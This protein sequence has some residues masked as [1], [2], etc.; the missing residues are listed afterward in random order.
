MSKRRSNCVLNSCELDSV[1]LSFETPLC[2]VLNSCKMSRSGGTFTD[3]KNAQTD[4]NGTPLYGIDK[5]LAEK[6]SRALLR[7]T[8]PA[9]LDPRAR[10]PE[11]LPA[12]T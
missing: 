3:L 2:S 10:D 1:S 9:S 4:A 8:S 11:R 6:A 12:V 7:V 5:E